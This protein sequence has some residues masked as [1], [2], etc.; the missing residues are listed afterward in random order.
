MLLDI[1]DYLNEEL[2][3]EEMEQLI[4]FSTDEKTLMKR[5]LVA[6]QIISD[7][8]S[9]HDPIIDGFGEAVDLTICKMLID[10]AIEFEQVNHKFH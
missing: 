9:K 6:C 7:L 1:N 3:S 5:Y 2:D 10:G 8:S 4:E